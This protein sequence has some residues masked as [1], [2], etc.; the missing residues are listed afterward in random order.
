M[1]STEKD[2]NKEGKLFLKKKVPKE[3]TKQN[4]V[5][6]ACCSIGVR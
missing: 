3:E 6:V 5:N 4:P 2:K 1:R